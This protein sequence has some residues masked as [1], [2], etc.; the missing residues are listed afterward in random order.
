MEKAIKIL[1]IM[2]LAAFLVWSGPHLFGYESVPLLKGKVHF[3]NKE[4]ISLIQKIDRARK[5]FQKT[6]QGNTYFTGYIFQS[7]DNIRMGGNGKPSEPFIVST[8][9]SRIKLQSQFKWSEKS[10]KSL[11]I[12]NG[13]EP[14]GIIFL[15]KILK[16][17][18]DIVAAHLIDLERNYEFQEEPIYWLG[19][20]NT[21]ESFGFLEDSFESGNDDLQ[22]TLVFIISLHDS[23]KTYD[24]L[25]RVA[26]GTYSKKIRENAIFWLGNYKDQKS[27]DY[28]K[29][30]YKKE[31][32]TKLR[33]QIIFA[34][35]LSD[36]KESVTEMIKIAKTSDNPQVRKNAIFW[37]GQKASKESIETLGDIVK[38]SSENIEVKKSAVF[39]I[40]QLPREKAVPMLIDIAR[41]NKS[42]KVR[43]NAIF[44]LGE[45]GDEEALK[46]FEEILLKK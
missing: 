27:L 6:R 13:A 14:A 2:P 17:N 39:A 35:S 19:N 7:R 20:A 11:S 12:D 16:N 8:K 15:H 28:L 36:R 33:K 24:F 44:W 10:S 42:A 9:N 30:I 26:L 45:T 21:E 43:K 41:T 3:L 32:D 23:T 5:E 25:R 34:L 31:K 40:S 46:F 1:V 4:N 18:V 37:L 29:E 38:E 22:K